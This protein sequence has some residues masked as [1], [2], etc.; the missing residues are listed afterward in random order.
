MAVQTASA[1]I[2]DISIK[3]GYLR[4]KRLFDIAFTLLFSPLLLIV[5]AAI[6]ICIKI[7]SPGPIFFR[8][9]RIGQD[10]VEFFM[11]KFRSMHANNDQAK[12]SNRVID[13]M[14]SGQVLTKD[15]NDKRITRVGRIIR[16]T[17][18]DELPQ[19]WNVLCGK[20]TLVGPRPP[21]PYEVEEYGARDW[22]RLV[23]KPGLTGTWQVYGRSRVTFSD[24]VSMDIEYLQKQSFWLDLKL[25]FLTV[26]VMLFARG[27]A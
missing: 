3:T 26:P 8:Q 25:I 20:M 11:L 10:G 15:Q 21:L 4:V 2:Q 16:K 1:S 17:S 24:M 27:G 19:F 18:L 9:K 5:G 12:H 7:D 13:L 23:G 14:R 6:A 22:L